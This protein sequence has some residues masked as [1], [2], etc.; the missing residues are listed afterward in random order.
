MHETGRDRHGLPAVQLVPHK[1]ALEN[2]IEA[3]IRVRACRRRV[4]LCT[5]SELLHPDRPE[6]QDD[7]MQSSYPA[8]SSSALPSPGHS[9]AA[10]L[11]LF[12]E[13]TRRA[14]SR[15]RRRRAHSDAQSSPPADDDDRGHPRMDSW[16]WEWA[17]PS[18]RWT[19]ARMVEYGR[20]REMLSNPSTRGPAHS[21][22]V[23]QG[24]TDR[25]C[26]AAVR[27]SGAVLAGVLGDPRR[28][29]GLE[30]G[31]IMGHV[32]RDGEPVAPG[33]TGFLPRSAR[34]WTST[35]SSHKPRG[36]ELRPAELCLPAPRSYVS[37]TGDRHS[38]P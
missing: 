5:A 34:A 1:T 17:T 23:P 20:P 4:R 24:C 25:G 36:L 31:A 13:P 10:K 21:A 15:A 22:K 8:A 16:R 2:V 29:P 14:G 18:S 37:W 26:Q 33:L 6:R 28:E 11:M 30:A 27:W 38:H 3:P 12:D 35:R 7:A 19:R 32:G 9:R